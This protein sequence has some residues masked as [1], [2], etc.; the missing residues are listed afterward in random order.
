MDTLAVLLVDKGD[1][2][3]ALELFRKALEIAPQASQIRL[4]YAKA[5]LKA[6]Q[7]SDARSELHQ[8]AK[9]GEKFPGQAEVA[10]LQKGL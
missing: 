6:G 1:T 8:L 9:L 2:A 7:K 4:N 5:L 3:R 10:Q